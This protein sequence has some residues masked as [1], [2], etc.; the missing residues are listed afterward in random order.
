VLDITP[1]KIESNRKRGIKE[2]FNNH[3]LTKRDASEPNSSF[4]A[5]ESLSYKILKL[6]KEKTQKRK[7]RSL[8]GEPVQLYVETLIVTDV[9]I[10]N[11]H[12]RITKSTDQNVVFQ[13]MKLYFSHVINGVN[14]LI[15]EFYFID[16][17]KFLKI[18]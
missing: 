8:N 18:F 4:D 3:L 13:H 2:N 14:K 5:K 10:Y 7:K 15:L 1:I 11:D 16:Y 9:S 6:R 17:L 12:Q